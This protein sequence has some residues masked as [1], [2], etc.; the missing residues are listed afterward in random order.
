MKIKPIKAVETRASSQDIQHNTYTPR[1]WKFLM[2]IVIVLFVLCFSVFRENINVLFYNGP[3]QIKTLADQSG[4]NTH[5]KALFFSTSPE[6]VDYPTLQKYCPATDD[7]TEFGCFIS[8]KNKIYILNIS[9]SRL[10]PLMVVA[11]SHEMLHKAYSELVSTEKQSVDTQLD[12]LKNSLIDNPLQ[13]YIDAGLPHDIILNELHSFVGTEVIVNDP[14][15]VSDY[16]KY[17]DGQTK[18][19]DQYQQQKN[20]IAAID[21]ELTTDKSAITNFKTTII[22]R[23][24]N[25]QNQVVYYINIAGR[26]GDSVNYYNNLR[27]YNSNIPIIQ[28]N[29]DAYNSLVDAYNAKL[30]DYKALF[31][32]LKS[33]QTL[34]GAKQI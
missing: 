4:M 32:N 16:S 24:E 1:A 21:T 3:S 8:D 18:I 2:V 10:A 14:I 33:V 28:K 31:N 6:V 9:D 13:P 34:P 22:D 23:D 15:L 12:L 25:N 11:A 20:T 5:G 27:V 26:N 30:L 17:F 19:V 7:I 29:I